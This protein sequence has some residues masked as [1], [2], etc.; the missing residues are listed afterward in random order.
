MG[1]SVLLHYKQEDI[2]QN[3]QRHNEVR[4][5]PGQQASLASPMFEPEEFRKQIYCIEEST[6]DVTLLGH[7]PPESFGSLMVIRRPG[8]CASLVTPLSG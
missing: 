1:R 8:N 6:C 3:L 4:W 7:A 5:R 2:C